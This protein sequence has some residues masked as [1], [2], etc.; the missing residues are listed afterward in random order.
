MMLHIESGEAEIMS[1]S[2]NEPKLV[3]KHL[4]RLK[5]AELS[6]LLG[7]HILELLSTLDARMTTPQALA[8]IIVKIHGERGSLRRREIR[9]FLLSRLTS[10]EG[11]S[12]CQMGQVSSIVPEN[13]LKG[14]DFDTKRNIEL[15]ERWYGVSSEEIASHDSQSEGSQKIIALHKL[16]PH[17]LNAFRSLRRA[18]ATPDSSVIVHMPYGSGKLRVVA[19]AALDLYR[20]ESEGKSIVWL[21]PGAALCEEAFQELAQVW[22]QTGLH[23]TTILQLYGDHPSRDLDQISGAIAVIDML[24]LNGTDAGL[25]ELGSNIM[26]AVFADAESIVHPLGGE[27]FRLMSEGGS[28]SK[29]GVLAAPGHSVSDEAKE[30]LFNI[31]PGDRITVENE[32][33]IQSIRDCGGFAGVAAEARDIASPKDSIEAEI[34]STLTDEAEALEHSGPDIEA[35]GSSVERNKNLLEILRAEARGDA[36]VIFYA[37]TRENARLIAGILLMYGVKARAV[38]GDLSSALRG[39][40]IQR[41]NAQEESVLCVH[42]FLLSES[43]TPDATVCVMASPAKSRMA[44]LSTIGRLVQSRAADLPPLRL[45]VATDTRMNTSWVGSLSSWSTLNAKDDA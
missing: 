3:E 6:G 29:V 20:S 40:E 25:K 45:I 34:Y 21:A 37:P 13:A 28:F 5:V 36:R 8:N 19:T 14:I 32:D 26:L 18:I 44:V 39:I 2:P 42:G 43:I 30:A 7:S 35:L 11:V 23:D 9:D 12:L 4:G 17:Q 27:I 22:K 33:Q 31:F 24:R 16:K 38:T 41:F 15:L 1:S 10:E